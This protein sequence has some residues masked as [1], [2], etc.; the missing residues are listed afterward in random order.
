MEEKESDGAK[1]PADC[2]G[3][4]GGEV[5]A[6]PSLEWRTGPRGKHVVIHPFGFVA[7]VSF[8]RWDSSWHWK[9]V[10]QLEGHESTELR[11]MLEA[12]NSLQL[13]IVGLSKLFGSEK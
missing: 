8:D 4:G 12:E 1:G 6:S 10:G 2:Q 9:T 5:S 13:F 11:A 7:D 3:L